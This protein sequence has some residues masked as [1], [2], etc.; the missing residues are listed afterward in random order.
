MAYNKIILQG[1]LTKDI[2]IRYRCKLDF[3]K[4]YYE[5]FR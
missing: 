5:N 2:E 1:N 4:D 3:L